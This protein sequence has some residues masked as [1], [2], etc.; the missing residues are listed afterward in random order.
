MSITTPTLDNFNRADEDPLS[1]DGNWDPTPVSGG[2]LWTDTLQLASNVAQGH[3]SALNGSWRVATTPSGDCQVWGRWK[4][5]VGNAEGTGLFMNLQS[6]ASS[7]FQGYRARYTNPSAGNN[8][9]AIH[10][11][12]AGGA[13]TVI[14]TTTSAITLGDG[15][16]FLLE[17]IGS[18]LSLYQSE[19]GVSFTFMCSASDSAYTGGHL[20]LWTDTD[21]GGW[22]GFG[23]TTSL[24]SSPQ[25]MRY[26]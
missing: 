14:G 10:K 25:V 16:Y 3:G 26:A 24:D 21:D 7:S 18:T 19:D 22:Q 17:K 4:F 15:D 12:T 1:Q 6:P 23:G 13:G 2:A 8:I 5:S 20:G 11:H 9:F